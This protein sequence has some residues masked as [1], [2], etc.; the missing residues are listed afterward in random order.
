MRPNH[1]SGED[2]TS[3]RAALEPG[4]RRAPQASAPTTSPSHDA[5]PALGL[6]LTVDHIRVSRSLHRPARPLVVNGTRS[7]IPGAQHIAV[8][9]QQQQQVVQLRPAR[10]LTSHT[11]I[12]VLVGSA[13]RAEAS[14]Q[15]ADISGVPSPAP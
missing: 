14:S 10:P 13:Q 6:K 2:S 12:V 8:A 5:A 9:K 3:V 1:L 7:R 4:E 11:D 15:A